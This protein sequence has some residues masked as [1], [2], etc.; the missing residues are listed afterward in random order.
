MNSKVTMTDMKRKAGALLDFISRTQV[1]LAGEALPE[2]SS[3]SP[4]TNGVSAPIA[5]KSPETAPPPGPRA[6]NGLDPG[7]KEFKELNCIEMMDTL[8]RRLVKWQQEYAV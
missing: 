3:S 5:E 2:T 6:A 7:S 4:K 8:T 1:E